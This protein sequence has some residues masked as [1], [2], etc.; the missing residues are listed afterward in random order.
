QPVAHR[1]LSRFL[2]FCTDKIGCTVPSDRRPATTSIL[3][4][5]DEAGNEQEKGQTPAPSWAKTAVEQEK[6]EPVKEITMVEEYAETKQESTVEENKGKDESTVEETKGKDES[7]AE[8]TVEE[9]GTKTS[10]VASSVGRSRETSLNSS[11]A[12]HEADQKYGE[13][14]SDDALVTFCDRL[15]SSLE[16]QTTVDRKFEGWLP[17][18][19]ILIFARMIAA[20]RELERAKKKNDQ[21]GVKALESE[22]GGSEEVRKEIHKAITDG[23]NRV[24]Q[25]LYDANR[26]HYV[27]VYRSPTREYLCLYDS[28]LNTAHPERSLKNINDQILAIF[29]H[30]FPEEKDIPIRIY[31]NYEQQSDDWSCG[32]RAIA[33]VL[34]LVFN[35]RPCLVSYNLEDIHTLLIDCLDT[36]EISYE[37]FEKKSRDLCH[38]MKS[39]EE[40]DKDIL[41]YVFRHNGSSEKE[42]MDEN[43]NETDDEK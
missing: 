42:E 12:F 9:T 1:M 8:S 26:L 20:K 33:C 41:Y 15:K 23:K 22:L 10:N 21:K 34:K 11:R 28:L 16:K 18:N 14:I 2:N 35:Q 29:G 19:T 37:Y 30:L 36:P 4:E 40:Y 25:I 7:T 17:I 6:I 24:C 38:P 5:R 3:L 31:L 32:Y 39:Y 13:R 43:N 27:V